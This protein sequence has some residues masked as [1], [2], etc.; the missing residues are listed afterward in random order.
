MWFC[1]GA[2]QAMFFFLWGARF[3]VLSRKQQ[4][5]AACGAF[6][7][8]G[9][10]LMLIPFI[11]PLVVSLAMVVLPFASYAL[12]M[13]AFRRFEGESSANGALVPS[14][15]R[16]IE[17]ILD[18]KKFIPFDEDRR[19]ILLKGLFALLYS[20]PL[21]FVACAVLCDWLYP[22]NDVVIGLSNASAALVMIIVLRE[23]ALDACN[24]LPQ[25]FLPIM[26]F[27][28]LLLGVLWPSEGVLVCAVALFTLFGCYEMI[29][30][31]TSYAYSS[32]DVVRC[33]WELYSSKAG[34]S[35]GF[36]LGWTSAVAVLYVFAVDPWWLLSLLFLAVSIAI[37]ADTLFFKKMK[38]EFR[39][40]VVD[41]GSLIE[42]LDPATAEFAE[43]S[44][45]GGRWNRACEELA[46]TY[47][48]SPRQKE[49][50]LLLAKGRNVQFIK[51][52]LVL[53]VPT[54][55]SHVYSIYQKMEIHSHQE[56]L[57]LVEEHIENMQ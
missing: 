3:R 56:L 12:L 30:A 17:G 51:D 35:T 49:I 42:A 47:K 7:S 53:S 50:F 26:S 9:L 41:E 23:H 16:R 21:G 24:V 57:D 5:Y 8:G 46:E 44:K 32:Y 55:K 31:Y 13:L 22:A 54:V 10:L 48:L 1:S 19:Y 45:G 11:D 4:L 52:K 29:N 2:G 36:F 39:E 33:L 15:V 43:S 34:N 18:L 28:C 14:D 37:V 38:L 6:A 40:V 27:S 20:I 25:L